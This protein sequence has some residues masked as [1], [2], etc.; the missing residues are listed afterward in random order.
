MDWKLLLVDTWL[1]RM[2][3]AEKRFCFCN[4]EC[5]KIH[6]PVAFAHYRQSCLLGEPFP[7]LERQQETK[8]I[9]CPL[10]LPRP[11]C[12]NLFPIDALKCLTSSIFASLATSFTSIPHAKAACLRNGTFSPHASRFSC[13]WG[14]D[15]P[16]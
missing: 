6:A 4:L 7:V 1:L 10:R 8:T 11:V 16:A 15:P 12:H 13:R 3:E 14:I 9:L 5:P 2:K